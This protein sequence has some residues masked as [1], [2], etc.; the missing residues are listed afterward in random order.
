MP[1]I[2]TLTRDVSPSRGR[3]AAKA[4][5]NAAR[6]LGLTQRELARVIGVSEATAS[7]MK[8]G[9]Y[10]LTEKPLE[11][12]LCLIRVFRSLAAISGGDA[13]TI[14]GWMRNPNDILGAPPRA[15]ILTATG[16]I[17]TLQYLDAARA[18]T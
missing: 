11:L 8:D 1:A 6:Q 7:R 4:A 17:E 14:K 9:G 12:S 18:P 16:L 5:F 13:E 3:V 15:L 10:E 2:A